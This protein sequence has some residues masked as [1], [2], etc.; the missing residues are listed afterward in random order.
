MTGAWPALDHWPALA[1]DAP[2]TGSSTRD[3]AL[4][5]VLALIAGGLLQFFTTLLRRRTDAASS[6]GTAAEQV[7]SGSGQAVAVLQR[8]LDHLSAENQS[9]LTRLAA[10]ETRATAAEQRA[11]EAEARAADAE[12]RARRAEVQTQTL[13]RELTELRGLLDYMTNPDRDAAAGGEW[14]AP[15]YSPS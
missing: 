14:G 5:V 4:T 2:A 13:G 12:R 10:A 11:G 3:I 9:M 7:A 6:L 15:G 8:A 1:A